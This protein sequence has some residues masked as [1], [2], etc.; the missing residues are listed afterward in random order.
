MS[1][2][3]TMIAAFWLAALP[4]GVEAQEEESPYEVAIFTKDKILDR[5][6]GALFQGRLVEKYPDGKVKWIS[7]VKAGKL[8]G[9]SKKFY[10]TGQ[11]HMIL[12]YEAGELTGVFTE[13]FLNGELKFQAEVGKQ[14]GCGGNDLKGFLFCYYHNDVYK[15]KYKNGGRIQLFTGNGLAPFENAFLPPNQIDGYRIMVNKIAR[16]GMFIEDSRD[17]ICPEARDPNIKYTEW[18]PR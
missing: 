17:I 7:L 3:K 13:Y 8:D 18:L 9:P 15:N 14:S 4:F 6:S 10:P 5:R 1:W 2:I 12:Q 11:T 16:N